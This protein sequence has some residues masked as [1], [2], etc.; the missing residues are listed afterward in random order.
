[1]MKSI[2][3][4][5]VDILIK[6]PKVL[7]E[8]SKEHDDKNGAGIYS[9]KNAVYN[10]IDER[11]A[12]EFI[13]K[14]YYNLK[15]SDFITKLSSE[16][17]I[18]ITE[19]TLIE[20]LIHEI[21]S[22]RLN[23]NPR[24]NTLPKDGFIVTDRN[25]NK[26][27]V[28]YRA[29]ID[30]KSWKIILKTNVHMVCSLGHITKM[31]LSKNTLVSHLKKE[32]FFELK[33]EICKRK[34]RISPN[35]RQFELIESNHSI[36][37]ETRE[38][39]GYYNNNNDAYL[40]LPRFRD[41]FH[42]RSKKPDSS[43]TNQTVK[44]PIEVNQDYYKV[45]E[46]PSMNSIRCLDEYQNQEVEFGS[47]KINLN[48]PKIKD[49]LFNR[50]NNYDGIL[51]KL[52]EYIQNNPNFRNL[53]NYL[54][55]CSSKQFSKF[56]FSLTRVAGIFLPFEHFCGVLNEFAKN[57]YDYCTEYSKS[58]PSMFKNMILHT[59]RTGINFPIISV[60]DLNYKL[61]KF[62]Q[63][64]NIRNVK[65]KDILKNV[66]RNFNQKKLS[67]TQFIYVLQILITSIKNKETKTKYFQKI[68]KFGSE[69]RSKK[70]KQKILELAKN[71]L[72]DLE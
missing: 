52:L 51:E 48:T 10:Y 49:M 41:H 33:C 16:L 56:L 5:I 54:I 50:D 59:G 71:L 14:N 9:H 39:L 60:V 57:N 34:F 61:E 31:D 67:F 6:N 24:Y 27:E 7:Y 29:I 1:M 35:L 22:L 36:R 8:L 11:N 58:A 66:L 30:N 13:L 21:N 3:K 45:I 64:E 12:F 65:L 68:K 53:H 32:K 62:N 70:N 2:R 47:F 37:D 19:A 46:L 28:I 23:I 18:R 38:S 40:E 55:N 72:K 26:M 43:N 20:G 42:S 17:G 63:I 69:E 4:E 15:F 25:T 44:G